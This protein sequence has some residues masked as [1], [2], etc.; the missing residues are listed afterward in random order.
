MIMP[1]PRKKPTPKDLQEI[2]AMAGCGMTQES[3]AKIKGI[4]VD[5]LRKYSNDVYQVGKAKGIGRV[6]KT[7]FEMAVSGKF[8]AMTIF[9]LKTQ[10]RWTEQ[11]SVSE[12]L[13][14]LSIEKERDDQ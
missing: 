8:P 7:A 1:R 2:E 10:A 4:S 12:F 5:T 3:V 11:P 14:A 9:F 13:E 6:A